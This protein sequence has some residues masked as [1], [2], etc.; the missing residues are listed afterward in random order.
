[1]EE[2]KETQE[3]NQLPKE[4]EQKAEKSKSNPMLFI[5]IAVAAVVVIGGFLLTRSQKDTIQESI[6]GTETEV[7]L[8]EESSERTDE[9]TVEE[10]SG[11]EDEELNIIE[12]EGGA[13]YFKP[14]EIRV[15]KGETV[16]IVFTN[17]GGSHDIVIDELNVKTKLTKTGEK[18]EVEFTANEA[19]EYEFYCSVMNHRALGMGGTLIVE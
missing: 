15:K 11:V 3:N 16:R 9:Q 1:M 6:Q 18:A 8:P 12:V 2:S 13:Y 19:G 7:Q 4:E 14:N 17:A 10:S 5:G